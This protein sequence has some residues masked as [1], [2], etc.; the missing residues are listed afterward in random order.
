MGRLPCDWTLWTWRRMSQSQRQRRLRLLVRRLNQERKQQAR[1]IDILC[2]DLI[3]ANRSLVRRLD[4]VSFAA[5][6]HKALLG[7]GNVRSVLERASCLIKQELPGANVA[8]FLR[9]GAD[10][11]LY[12]LGDQQALYLADRRLADCFGP[13][14]ADN[15]CKSNKRC[16]LDDMFGMGLE[17]NLNGLNKISIATLPLNDLGRALGFILLYR[18]MP[19]QLTSEE[20]HKIGLITCGLSHAIQGCRPPVHLG[21]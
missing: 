20:L 6:F 7:A 11:E 10:C 12:A 16:T 15:I 9:Q 3:A 4:G 8:F 13:E 21:H 2:S 17:G 1:K 18:P 14:L 5:G 19:H